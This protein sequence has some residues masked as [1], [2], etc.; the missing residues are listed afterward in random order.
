MYFPVP[1]FSFFVWCVMSSRRGSGFQ[2]MMDFTITEVISEGHRA[3]NDSCLTCVSI[4]T[5]RFCW[6]KHINWQ[7]SVPLS[8]SL[9]VN[10][11]HPAHRSLSLQSVLTSNPAWSSN[12]SRLLCS[13]GHESAVRTGYFVTQQFVVLMTHIPLRNCLQYCLIVSLTYFIILPLLWPEDDLRTDSF[14][15]AVREL[16]V[17]WSVSIQIQLLQSVAPVLIFDTSAFVINQI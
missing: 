6:D 12:T 9:K 5:E 13:C 3:E 16:N 14:I 15:Q 2:F 7:R 10:L 4:N 11:A 17:L 8:L 1:F